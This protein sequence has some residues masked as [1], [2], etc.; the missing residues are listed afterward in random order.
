MIQI[1]G[2]ERRNRIKNKKPDKYRIYRV[3]LGA[4]EDRTGD[5]LNAIRNREMENSI[6]K[7]FSYAWES[8]LFGTPTL[9]DTFFKNYSNSYF[10]G[11]YK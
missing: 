11:S 2:I 5:P 8:P 10:P 3:S 4:K 9:L 1:T 6:I 7:L